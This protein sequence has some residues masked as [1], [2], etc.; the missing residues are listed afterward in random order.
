VK[1]LLKAIIFDF[2][3][4]SAIPEIIS[5][6]TSETNSNPPSK[7]TSTADPT[8]SNSFSSGSSLSTPQEI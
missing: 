8:F 4:P 7:T 6:T 2:Y 3:K 1:S 5:P